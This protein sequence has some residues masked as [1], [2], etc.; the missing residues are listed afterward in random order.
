MPIINLEQG[1]S[2]WLDY[3]KSKIMAT[4]ASVLMDT[5]PWKNPLDLWEE[6]LGIKSSQIL[7]EAVERGH[8]L[9]PEA[10][11]LAIDVIGMEF[12]PVVY[13]SDKYSFM[14]ASL[15][16]I[17]QFGEHLLEIKCPFKEDKHI[18]AIEGLVPLYYIDQIQHQ[19]LVTGASC[20]FYFSY[21]PEFKEKP[22]AMV[23]FE[24]NANRQEQILIKSQE[25]YLQ[26]CTM[27]PPTYW[28]L[29]DH[30]KKNQRS[31]LCV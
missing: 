5:N 23:V 30:S 9:E 1:T 15:D 19:L 2:S 4:D 27:Q 29:K 20:C 7:N 10:R 11:Q 21:R 13:E 22:F 31:I 6:K 14:A 25:F 12:K 24:P 16:G 3:R 18:D 28:K 26:L 8:Q 17:S